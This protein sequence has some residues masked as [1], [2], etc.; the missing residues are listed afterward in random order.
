[1]LHA[2]LC[3]W[4]LTYTGW[5]AMLTR[6]MLWLTCCFARYNTDAIAL[7]SITQATL[8]GLQKCASAVHCPFSV[9]HSLDGHPTGNFFDQNVPLQCM[10]S[11][12][13]SCMADAWV[14]RAAAG[15]LIGQHVCHCC[16][17]SRPCCVCPRVPRLVACRMVSPMRLQPLMLHCC[18]SCRLWHWLGLRSESEY[19]T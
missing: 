18:Q 12:C 9:L 16:R 1:V 5:K 4:Q 3:T 7:L 8:C 6:Y 2:G 17:P 10:A 11:L 15:E 13:S 14:E 19:E